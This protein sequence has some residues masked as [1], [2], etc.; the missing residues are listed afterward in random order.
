MEF[1]FKTSVEASVISIST[2]LKTDINPYSMLPMRRLYYMILNRIKL[3]NSIKPCAICLDISPEEVS[4]LNLGIIYSSDPP[5]SF[6]D[7]RIKHKEALAGKPQIFEWVSVIKPE[8]SFGLKSVLK[9]LLYP[10]K[11]HLLFFIRNISDRKKNEE[12]AYRL[13]NI[14]NQIGEGVAT[15]DLN[16]IITYTNQ[17]WADMHGYASQSLIGKHLSMFPQR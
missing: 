1:Q 2:N 13:I 6:H 10:D 17:A 16:G 9:N 4:L 14:V 8:T 15:A 5:Y 11:S 12:R 7:A 3:L